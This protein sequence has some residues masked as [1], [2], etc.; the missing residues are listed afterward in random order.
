MRAPLIIPTIAVFA[1]LATPHGLHAQQVGVQG[2]LNRAGIQ[3]DAPP[4]AQYT[5]GFGYMAGIVVDLPIATDVVLSL[6]PMYAVRGTGIA[7]AVEGEEE[8]RDSLDVALT[9]VSVPLLAK[10]RAAHGRTYVTGG[11]DVGWLLDA[12]LTG[13]GADEDIASAFQDVDVAA[14]FGFGVVFP[15][16]R[17]R[18]TL[19]ARYTQS[20]LNLSAGGEVPDGAEL[21]ER[22]RANGFQLLTGLVI[23]LG[24]R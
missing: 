9:Y 12:T 18:L 10:V 4:N 5:G 11:V 21:P 22:F 2:G 19:E 7:F 13:R 20:L 14:L 6:Q 17:P 3:G 23:P 1:V 24:G 16:G 15:I 8:P